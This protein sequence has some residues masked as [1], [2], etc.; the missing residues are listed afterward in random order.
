MMYNLLITNREHTET[1]LEQDCNSRVAIHN[2]L[3][4]HLLERI[5]IYT[6]GL[7]KAES[8]TFH[9]A[10]WALLHEVDAYTK[11]DNEPEQI[12]TSESSQLGIIIVITPASLKVEEKLVE[13]AEV[14]AAA[15]KPKPKPK[16]TAKK[17]A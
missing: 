5:E 15:D 7:S 17:K 9:H 11:E 16:T 4:Q 1:Y 8:E 10:A 14:I 6:G 12:L 3:A 13:I 2:A